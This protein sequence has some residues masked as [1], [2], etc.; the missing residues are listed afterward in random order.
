[1]T[2]PLPFTQS[3]VA[4]EVVQVNGTLERDPAAVNRDPYGEGWMVSLRLAN[5]SA[6]DGLLSPGAYRSH[7]GE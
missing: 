7:I 4:G 5:P 6:L 3:P 1:M 2:H